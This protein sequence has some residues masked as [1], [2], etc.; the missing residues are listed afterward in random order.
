MH[1]VSFDFCRQTRANL[2]TSPYADMTSN[3]GVAW[4]Y[5]PDASSGAIGR[6]YKI[7]KKLE[8]RIHIRMHIQHYRHAYAIGLPSHEVE[9]VRPPIVTIGEPVVGKYQGYDLTALQ[10]YVCVC[11]FIC[12][13]TYVCVVKQRSDYYQVPCVVYRC[14]CVCLYVCMYVCMCMSI[15]CVSVVLKVHRSCLCPHIYV[16]TYINYVHT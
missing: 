4:P 12:C 6:G 14:V 5:E 8:R 15:T 7:Q 13:C 11:V 1:Q 2:C 10:L 9:I 16:H 3:E